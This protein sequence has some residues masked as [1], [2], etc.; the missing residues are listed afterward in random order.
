MLFKKKSVLKTTPNNLWNNSLQLP[1]PMRNNKSIHKSCPHNIIPNQT[2]LVVSTF[3]WQNTLKSVKLLFSSPSHILHTHFVLNGDWWYQYGWNDNLTW[4]GGRRPV[5]ITTTL[6]QTKLFLSC[7]VYSHTASEADQTNTGRRRSNFFYCF[8][9]ECK[10]LVL[11]GVWSWCLSWH[12]CHIILL[13]W[14]GWELF[15]HRIEQ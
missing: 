15:Q 10:A 7:Q 13:V 3:T 12:E 14:C 6:F 9:S 4:G 8:E 2:C 5:T 1:I 11:S